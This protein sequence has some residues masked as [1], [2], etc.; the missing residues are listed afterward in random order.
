MHHTTALPFLLTC[1]A[2]LSAAAG[3]FF[4]ECSPSWSI[5]YRSSQHFIV[6]TCPGT[7]Y[8]SADANV[9]SVTSALSMGDCLV[10][11]EGSLEAQA[12]GGATSFCRNCHGV[13]GTA[14]MLCDCK[15]SGGYYITSVIDLNTVLEND[16]GILS[17]FG[18]PGFAIATA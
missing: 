8:A 7:G 4:D 18:L 9:T 3:G 10:N 1:L 11:V 6:A 15:E 2:T 16:N 5:G 13:S 14:K 17:C 12:L